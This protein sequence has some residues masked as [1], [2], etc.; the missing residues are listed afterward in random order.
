MGEL[1]I[2][3]QAVVGSNP[4]ISKLIKGV[5]EVNDKEYKT[6][7]DKG[8]SKLWKNMIKGKPLPERDT[9]VFFKRYYK[10][11]VEDEKKWLENFK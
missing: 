3:N 1:L 9:K 5:L 6:W 4:A 2:C 8:F 11:S 7:L 10:L